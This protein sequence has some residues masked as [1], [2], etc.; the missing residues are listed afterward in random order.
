MSGPVLGK[1]LVGKTGSHATGAS[2]TRARRQSGAGLPMDMHALQRAVGNQATSRL[3]E[4]ATSSPGAG[5]D[6]IA[7]SE[8]EDVTRSGGEPLKNDTRQTM[9]SRFGYDLSQVKVHHD[10]G[11]QRSAQREHALAYTSG[12]HIAFARGMYSPETNMG[13]AILAHELSHVIQQT[14]AI[15]SAV[16]R[17]SAELEGEAVAASSSNGTARVSAGSAAPGSVQKLEMQSDPEKDNIR[18]SLKN[19]PEAWPNFFDNPKFKEVI[20]EN[21]D[22]GRTLFRDPDYRRAI[23]DPSFRPPRY[24]SPEERTTPA[25]QEVGTSSPESE[26][27]PRYSEIAPIRVAKP[28]QAQG[29]EKKP[30][31]KSPKDIFMESFERTATLRQKAEAS[32]P[33]ALRQFYSDYDRAVDEGSQILDI[34][35]G[36]KLGRLLGEL[37]TGEKASGFQIDRWQKAKETL[38]EGVLTGSIVVGPEEILEKLFGGEAVGEARSLGS[39]GRETVADLPPAAPMEDVI[40]RTATPV[41]EHPPGF[42]EGGIELGPSEA[43]GA[44]GETGPPLE[45]QAERSAEITREAHPDWASRRKSTA[46][47]P[48]QTR[49]ES[50][51]RSMGHERPPRGI[52]ADVKKR[53]IAPSPKSEGTLATKRKITSEEQQFGIPTRESW[54]QIR[55][56]TPTEAQS[57]WAQEQ[58]PIGS[59]DPAFPGSTVDMPAQPDHLIPVSK[60]R[61]YEGFAA[62]DEEGQLEVLNLQENLEAMSAKAN[63]LKGGRTPT[64][65]FGSKS[66][67]NLPDSYKKYLSAREQQ[68]E[69]AIKKK[70]DELLRKKLEHDW[71][72]RLGE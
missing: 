51:L 71:G 14:P 21:P 46:E 12:Q 32:R 54:K 61:Q 39:M 4:L 1:S 48:G 13:E 29:Q 6:S 20:V 35:P 72:M 40:E 31:K 16:V 69:A 67:R 38:I 62:L 33:V 60:A 66:G 34:L 3:V 36:A 41:A 53:G 10:E 52:S 30:A 15:S 19:V 37:I 23:Q 26:E 68:A 44:S 58:L 17:T 11:A 2:V 28:S 18:R 55:L 70:I 43:E 7:G 59:P 63:N 49:T 27:A 65:W 24:R 64:E 47:L 25:L 45:S 8:V 9:E 5:A 57:I 56:Q 50:P 42:A 22:I